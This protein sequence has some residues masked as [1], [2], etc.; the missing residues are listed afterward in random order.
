MNSK[1][2]IQCA[3][4]GC[5]SKRG[6]KESVPIHRFSNRG[7]AGQRWIEASGNFYL[8]RLEFLQVVERKL[9]VY[10]RQMVLFFK[11]AVRFQR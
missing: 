1:Y 11:S 4:S 6:R 9:F 5:T 2:E 7:D 8:S 10:H 3:V